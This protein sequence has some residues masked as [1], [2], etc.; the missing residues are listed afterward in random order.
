MARG[1]GHMWGF[2]SLMDLEKIAKNNEL[3]D[4][5]QCKCCYDA[6]LAK[7]GM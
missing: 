2:D 4:V 6:I 7:H 5:I 3:L 1:G